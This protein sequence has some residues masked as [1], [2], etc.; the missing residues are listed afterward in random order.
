MRTFSFDNGDQM[1]ILG[2]GTWKTDN[3]AIKP[4]IKQA[5]SIG[6]R[7][8]DCAAVYGN[9]VG[10]GEALTEAFDAKEVTREQLWVT[11]KLWNNAHK[12]DD[13]LPALKKTLHSLQ[14][15]YLDLYLIHWPVAVKPEVGFPQS[16]DDYLSLEELPIIETWQA[17]EACFETGLIR[18]IGVSNF[19]VKKLKKLL[20]QSRINPEVNQVELHPLLQQP[21]MKKYCD[22]V[23]IN[24]T[25][26]APLGSG[27]RPA[28][29]QEEGSP[30]PLEQPV[31]HEIAAAH[32]ATP[33]QVLLAWG[34]QRGTA[35][36][37]K[38]VKAQRMEENLA[39]SGLELS[40][41]EMMQIQSLDQHCRLLNGK[42]WGGPYTYEYLWDEKELG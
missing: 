2:L 3:Q 33:A 15:D 41:Q 21:E 35:V 14:L 10:I 32:D 37:P 6:Y 24:L 8:I 22:S 25:A 20:A 36:I 12:A 9:E 39:A 5:I 19:S 11:S 30:N 28:F 4:V 31:I 17:M 7:H 18:H 23:G 38:T 27:D 34:I 26:Y 16:D 40:D 42:V 1:P 29:F 13:V